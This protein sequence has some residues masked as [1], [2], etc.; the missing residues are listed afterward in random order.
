M[1]DL[2]EIERP[3][4]P[5]MDPRCKVY[6]RPLV[7]LF[8]LVLASLTSVTAANQNSDAVYFQNGNTLY[9]L[10]VGNST[11]VEVVSGISFG[12]GIS[13]SHNGH[14]I[15]FRNEEGFWISQ[16]ADWYPELVIPENRQGGYGWYWTPDDNR[17]IVN[18]S[19]WVAQGERPQDAETIAYN[20]MTHQIETWSWG[21]CSQIAK[22]LTS[23]RLALVCSAEWWSGNVSP[24]TIAIQWGGEFVPY[25]EENY[26]TLVDGLSAYD[27][28]TNSRVHWIQVDGNDTLASLVHS[29][30]NDAIELSK[31]IQF[32]SSANGIQTLDFAERYR[33]SGFVQV[34]P[35]GNLIAYVVDCTDNQPKEC[36]Q[37]YSMDQHRVVW[38]NKR[39][40]DV[41][42]IDDLEW[43]S[44]NLHL[45]ILAK[46]SLTDYSIFVLNYADG[47]V[48]EYPVGYTSGSIAVSSSTTDTTQPTR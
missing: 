7:A 33:L 26:M 46:R 39:N 4:T 43:F 17:L 22:N 44:D 24:A 31:Q 11:I 29:Q 20:L 35:D 45:A 15:A 12:G 48:R 42:F 32:Y 13:F 1:H 8:S 27:I 25:V 40:L 14:Y 36:L 41:A 9:R 34:S 30:T 23:L 10:D 38:D 28:A 3:V 2:R 37:I 5:G 6:F 21:N 19:S 18:V 16:L 47:L